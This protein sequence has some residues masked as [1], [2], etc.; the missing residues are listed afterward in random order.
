MLL[1][2]WLKM[3][4]DFGVIGDVASVQAKMPKKLKRRRP[5]M[6]EDGPAGYV[7]LFYCIKFFPHFGSCDAFKLD[8][9]VLNNLKSITFNR[10]EEYFDYMFP[11]ETQT[12]NLKILEAAY[13]WK[14][15]KTGVDDE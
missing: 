11:E 7:K 1:D 10:F 14:K 9:L 3:E 8:L 13:K 15:Q 6:T 4:K 12:T 2:E 5:L